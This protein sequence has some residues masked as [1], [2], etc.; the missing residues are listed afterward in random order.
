MDTKTLIALLA[1]VAV[2][3]LGLLMRRG[4][5]STTRTM[6]PQPD[7]TGDDTPDQLDEDAAAAEAKLSESNVPLS[8]DGMA[9]MPQA[10]G[11][12]LLPLLKSEEAPDW[13]ERAMD[14]SAV[15]YSQLNHWYGQGTRAHGSGTPLGVGDL[16]AAR[17]VR[18]D[19]EDPWRLET[20]G[21]DGDFGLHAFA[22]RESADTALQ[23]LLDTGVVRAAVDEHGD[24]VP[25][26][27]E[28]FEE[29]RRRYEQTLSELAM[30]GDDEPPREGQ[31]LS[32]R[33]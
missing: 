10:H 17:V 15:P 30:E 31:W 33:R 14:A 13:V 23:M 24:H 27:S 1:V 19:S 12:I 11:V 8:M 22:T 28:D 21:R 2:A 32:D 4:G 3:V 6:P 16:T 29:A 9:F 7:A 26:S 20:L 5:D 25:P 18:G